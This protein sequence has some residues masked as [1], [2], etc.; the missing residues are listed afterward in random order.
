MKTI[1]NI[2]ICFLFFGCVD[3]KGKQKEEQPIEIK[4]VS[5][6]TLTNEDI[7]KTRNNEFDIDRFKKESD[8]LLK[9]L[10][11]ENYS[12]E[13]QTDI[14]KFKTDNPETFTKGHGIFWQLYQDSSERIVRHHFF[15]PNTKKQ[16]RIY[17]VEAEYKNKEQMEKVI[18]KLEKTMNDSINAPD[19]DDF[20]KWRLSPISDYIIAS[21]NKMYWL[22]GS[23]PYSNKEF[24]KFI[25]CLKNNLDTTT[26]RG[27]IICLFGK[28]CENENVP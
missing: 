13:L 20:Q 1:I 27:R 18:S 3:N 11:G 12:F 17:L 19:S 7:S 9:S 24:L 21:D 26:Y 6:D 4:E 2:T 8:S 10:K 28:D 22:N 15:V 5:I 16:L 23:Y 14:F 25:D